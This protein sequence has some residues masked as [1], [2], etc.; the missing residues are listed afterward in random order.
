MK[1]PPD[2]KH[3]IIIKILKDKSRVKAMINHKDIFKNIVTLNSLIE[4]FSDA[5]PYSL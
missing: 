2:F 1:L 4:K 5:E 3:R